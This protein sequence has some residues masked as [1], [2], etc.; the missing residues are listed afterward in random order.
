MN[1]GSFFLYGI[2]ILVLGIAIAIAIIVI[3]A[4]T[5]CVGLTL[6]IIPFV[7]SVLLLPVSYTYRAFSIEFLAQFGD[8]YDVLNETAEF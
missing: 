6:L 5:C 1:P 8:E 2:L 3:A 7:G 4:A